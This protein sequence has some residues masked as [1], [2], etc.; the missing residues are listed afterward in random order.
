MGLG[1]GQTRVQIL[2]LRLV[3]CMMLDKLFGLSGLQAS[4]GN[5]LFMGMILTEHLLWVKVPM[6]SAQEPSRLWEKTDT[7][8]WKDKPW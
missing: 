5:S 6:F 7:C 3:S 2:F 1:V 4:Y 8:I